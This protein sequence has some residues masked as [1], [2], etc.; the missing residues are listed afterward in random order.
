MKSAPLWAL[1]GTA[2]LMAIGLLAWPL[3]SRADAPAHDPMDHGAHADQAPQPAHDHHEA[4]HEGHGSESGPVIV[5]GGVTR[6]EERAYSLFMHRSCGL[7]VITLG[8][9]VLA[10]RFTRRRYAMLR[11]GMGAIWLLMGVH[12]LFN[13]DPTDWPLAATIM[14][15]Y[16]RPGSGEWLQHKLLSLV[17]IAIGLYTMAFA[18]RFKPNPY[19][20]YAMAA[21]LA[22]AGAALLFHEHEHAPGMDMALIVKQHN[23]MALTAIIIAAGWVAD[24]MERLAWK[25][26]LYVVPVGLILLGLELAV[27]TE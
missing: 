22:L 25:P 5:R 14:E 11:K 8:A 6:E 17:P 24:A 21:V 23:I 4:A 18:P 1:A 26:K 20:A 10:D 12:I 27:Y 13:A 2:L 19:A 15:S 16:S 3:L 9:F 7:A